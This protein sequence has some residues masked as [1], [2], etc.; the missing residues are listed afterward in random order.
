MT[1]LGGDFDSKDATLLRTICEVHREIYDCVYFDEPKEKSVEKLQEAF[2]MA[3]KL[4]NKLVQYKHGY[5]D[6]WWEENKSKG[7]SLKPNTNSED[8][9]TICEV[10]G[11]IYY[12][13]L[14]D[15]PN[16]KIILLLREAFAM[17]KNIVDR[18]VQYKHGYTDDHFGENKNREKS[19]RLRANR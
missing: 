19:I 13:L 16:E 10:H 1:G 12:Y 7:E 11:E 3:T 8:K 5:T 17:G 2:A 15:G 6:D 9:R 18:L 14:N 4:V